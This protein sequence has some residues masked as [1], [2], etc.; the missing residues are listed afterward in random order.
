MS[1]KDCRVMDKTGKMWRVYSRIEIERVV[2]AFVL[3]GQRKPR[4]HQPVFRSS[5]EMSICQGQVRK[6]TF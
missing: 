6:V 1:S 2:S 4:A 3:E 5:F